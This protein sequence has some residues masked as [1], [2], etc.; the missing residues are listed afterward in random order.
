MRRSGK[1]KG[2]ESGITV[3]NAVISACE[4]GKQP[5]KAWELLVVM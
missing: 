1:G 5:D 4:K 2:L 3:C